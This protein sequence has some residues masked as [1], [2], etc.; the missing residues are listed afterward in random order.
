[1]APA[2]VTGSASSEADQLILQIANLKAE[3]QNGIS[4]NRLSQTEIDSY[5][6]RIAVKEKKLNEL[7]QQETA[8]TK[9]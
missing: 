5:N 7:N 1:V 3:L 2:S 8:V 9:Q 4:Q 6:T